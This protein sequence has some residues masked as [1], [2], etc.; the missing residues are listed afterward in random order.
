MDEWWRKKYRINSNALSWETHES[1]NSA[2]LAYD[3]EDF[4]DYIKSDRYNNAI[5]IG[6]C[7]HP[8]IQCTS[9]PNDSYA[10]IV[11]LDKDGNQFWFHILILVLND[12][13]KTANGAEED[14]ICHT[15]KN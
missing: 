13:I 10:G 4:E 9:V 14:F 11:C 3:F 2:L 1:D 8:Y 5:P 7:E 15:T 6:I 12:W